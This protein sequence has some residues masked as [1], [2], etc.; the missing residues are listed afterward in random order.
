MRDLVPDDDERIRLIHLAEGSIT[1]GA[2]RNF[3]C[4]RAAGEYIAHWDDDDYSA[5]GRLADQIE[6]LKESGKS[7]TGYQF[8]PFT[9]GAQW[10]LYRGQAELF[11]GNL[12]VL[13]PR[14][15]EDASVPRHSGGRRQRVRHRRRATAGELATADAGDLMYATI[16]RGNTSPKNLGSS[17]IPIPA[18]EGL[19]DE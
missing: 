5:P 6:R 14:V 1:I 3:G 11:T 18:P 4:E 8:M 15:V 16:H 2:K 19:S 12:A 10:W 7:V 13:S 9:D 17:Y